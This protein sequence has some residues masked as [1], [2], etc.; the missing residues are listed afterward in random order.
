[1]D[2]AWAWVE[3][4]VYRHPVGHE[5]VEVNLEHEAPGHF[6]GH[7]INSTRWEVFR[8][9]FADSTPRTHRISF[10]HQHPLVRLLKKGDRIKLYPKAM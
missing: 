9:L 6:R 1:M 2:G 5:Q 3:V 8:C 10:D 7:M 4:A